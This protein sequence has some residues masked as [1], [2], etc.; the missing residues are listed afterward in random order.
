MLPG[1]CTAVSQRHTYSSLVVAEQLVNGVKN[2]KRETPEK[3]KKK[4]S[5]LKKGK[6]LYANNRCVILK[7]CGLK[8]ILIWCALI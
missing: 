8:P 1:A 2:E 3:P 6:V 5:C 4:T 7:V